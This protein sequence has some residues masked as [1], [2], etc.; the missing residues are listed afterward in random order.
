MEE[1]TW[2]AGK[3]GLL[4]DKNYCT[5]LFVFNY[6]SFRML[7]WEEPWRQN[8]WMI[9][10]PEKSQKP[11][12]NK[13]GCDASLVLFNKLTQGIHDAINWFQFSSFGLEPNCFHLDGFTT[14]SI[15]F[16]YQWKFNG[17]RGSHWVKHTNHGS[18]NVCNN[19]RLGSKLLLSPSPS[20]RSSEKVHHSLQWRP[21]FYFCFS[22]CSNVFL[23]RI[24]FLRNK[25]TWKSYLVRFNPSIILPFLPSYQ[26]QGDRTL[27]ERARGCRGLRFTVISVRQ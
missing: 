22:F 21:K 24:A 17:L 3:L 18:N 15:L 4:F 6:E 27:V 16:Y 8:I 23:L 7:S 25:T 13:I 9:L 26:T 12:T 2:P 10:P 14:Y 11:F 5:E 20:K 1:K 19:I